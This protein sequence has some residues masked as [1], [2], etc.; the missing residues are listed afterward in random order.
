MAK[1][2]RPGAAARTSGAKRPRILCRHGLVYP[3]QECIESDPQLREEQEAYRADAQEAKRLA[4]A[5]ATAQTL[6]ERM[7]EGDGIGG[8]ECAALDSVHVG[9]RMLLVYGAADF[10]ALKLG[11]RAPDTKSFGLGWKF[12]LAIKTTSPD[13]AAAWLHRVGDYAP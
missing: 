13:D 3:C 6:R 8:F 1:Q 4:P 5:R 11:S 12:L 9:E 2:S 10:A 7:D